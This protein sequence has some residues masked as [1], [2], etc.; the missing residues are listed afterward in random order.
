MVMAMSLKVGG[1]TLALHG[2]ITL[3]MIEAVGLK[4]CSLSW[5]QRENSNDQHQHILVS[6][7]MPEILFH[8]SQSEPEQSG[9]S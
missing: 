1:D 9:M 3:L 8:V 6:K 2:S 7:C 4:H 5:E